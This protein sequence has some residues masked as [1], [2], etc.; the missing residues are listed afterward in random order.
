MN[1]YSVQYYSHAC[2]YISVCMSMCV[3]VCRGFI[4]IPDIHGTSQTT[5]FPVRQISIGTFRLPGYHT[6]VDQSRISIW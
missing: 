5:C 1:K 6:D 4:S 3:C 2:T